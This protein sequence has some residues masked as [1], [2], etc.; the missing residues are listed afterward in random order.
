V[1][2]AQREHAA[3]E[4][5]LSTLRQIQADTQNNAPLREWLERHG[6]AAAAQLWQKLRIDAGWETAVEAVLRERLHALPSDAIDRGFSERPP[7]KAS[8]FEP[9][10]ALA[11]GSASGLP[12]AGKVHALDHSTRRA[13]SARSR[14]R[15]ANA[16][17]GKPRSRDR[18]RRSAGRKR[19]GTTR[20]SSSS[21]S[22][23]RRSATGNAALSCTPNRPNSAP[24]PNGGGRRWPPAKARRLALRPR[25]ARP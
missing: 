3:A 7:A 14:G 24:K 16:R 2:V 8:L 11:T 19:R 10:A 6:L 22:R 1:G 9:A 23:R 18:A 4:A 15:R 12:L 21:S 17:R 20:R 13:G 25:T 5:Q